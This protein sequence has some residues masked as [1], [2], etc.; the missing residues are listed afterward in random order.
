MC[1]YDAERWCGIA[2]RRGEKKIQAPVKIVHAFNFLRSALLSLSHTQF[3][4][5]TLANL[6]RARHCNFKCIPRSAFAPL[7]H[8]FQLNEII[9][10]I[11]IVRCGMIRSHTKCASFQANENI[12]WR[13]K[14]SISQININIYGPIRGVHGLNAANA[15]NWWIFIKH[16]PIGWIWRLQPIAH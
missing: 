8:S 16:F 2:S 7:I 11:Y 4:S 9:H 1:E 6:A 13:W 15:I 10:S 5:F 14:K 3:V 12:I